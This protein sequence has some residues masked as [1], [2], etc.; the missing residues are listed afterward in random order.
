MALYNEIL[1][2][3]REYGAELFG[4][5]ST[6][7]GVTPRSLATGSCGSLLLSD[8]EP[9][10]A[11]SRMYGAYASRRYSERALFVLDGDGI[12]RWSYCRTG[13][14]EPRC[15]RHPQRA[16]VAPPRAEPATAPP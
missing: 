8:F 15:R 7:P 9:K 5:S 13:R 2:E 14:R 1:P 3:F 16:R 4:I 6:V 11:V 10:G 12:V